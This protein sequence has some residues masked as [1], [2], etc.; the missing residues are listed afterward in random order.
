[1]GEEPRPEA[2]GHGGVCG[3]RARSRGR[4]RAGTKAVVGSE[5]GAEAPCERARRRLRVA[6]SHIFVALWTIST[7][8]SNHVLKTV[9]VL[10]KWY[11]V[12]QIG[13]K[14]ELVV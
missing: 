12:T 7:L 1:M 14:V 6:R 13:T 3:R 10:N 4:R 11:G 2:G 9:D 8:F 5:R